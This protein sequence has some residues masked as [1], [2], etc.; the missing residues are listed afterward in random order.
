MIAVA[1]F[2]TYSVQF[3]VP[4]EV[5]WSRM[6]HRYTRKNLAEYTIRYILIVRSKTAMR[7]RPSKHIY[8]SIPDAH[9]SIGRGHSEYWTISGVDRRRH[10]QLSGTH[11]SGHHTNGDLLGRDGQDTVSVDDDQEHNVDCVRT[12]W[13]HHWHVRLYARHY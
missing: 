8:Q 10:A 9:R 1:I 11:I 12:D 4:M 6:Q 2:L 3:Y 5:V 7:I 13:I